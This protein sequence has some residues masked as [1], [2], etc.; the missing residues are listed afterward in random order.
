MVS[1]LTPKRRENGTKWL[2]FRQSNITMV[3]REGDTGLLTIRQAQTKVTERNGNL[4]LHCFVICRDVPG[5]QKREETCT[6]D[7]PS[8]LFASVKM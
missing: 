1:S 3:Y 6:R 2:I 7:P 8:R 5:I 4:H